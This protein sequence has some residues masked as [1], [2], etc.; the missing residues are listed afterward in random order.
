MSKIKNKIELLEEINKFVP[1]IDG[2]NSVSNRIIK[3]NYYI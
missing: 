3:N 1:I 2:I